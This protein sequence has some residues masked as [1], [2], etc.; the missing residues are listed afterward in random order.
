MSKEYFIYDNKL[1]G[2]GREN[3]KLFLKN[4]PEIADE[5]ERKII[6]KVSIKADNL[7]LE[8]AIIFLYDLRYD[9]GEVV[10]GV[11]TIRL[12]WDESK[13]SIR[14]LIH[15]I[16]KNNLQGELNKRVKEKMEFDRK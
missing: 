3:A 10:D 5:I 2:Q 7:S 12:P 15:H 4:N 14:Q 13:Y 1:L 9:D 8:E 6:D 11:E 16:T